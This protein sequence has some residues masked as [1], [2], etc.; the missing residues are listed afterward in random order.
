MVVEETS[1]KPHIRLIQQIM[2]LVK[3]VRILSK[4]KERKED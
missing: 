2:A 4:D 1:D 3:S